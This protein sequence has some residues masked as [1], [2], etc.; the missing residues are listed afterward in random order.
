MFSGDELG[1]LL[2]SALA[3]AG[4]PLTV[5]ATRKALPAGRKPSVKEV[6]DRLG[7]LVDAGRIYRWPGATKKFSAVEPHAFAREH[8]LRALTPGPLTEAEVKK[9]VAKAAQPLVK[10]ALTHLVDTGV[11]RRH[12]KLGQKVPYGLGPPDP[13]AYLPA[14]IASAFKPLLKLGFT[15][16]AL[17][18]AL[19]EYVARP[20]GRGGTDTVAAIFA[21]MSTLNSQASRGALVYIAEL[22]AALRGRFSDKASFDAAILAL[23]ERGEVQL[24]SHAWPGR[25][26][27]AEKDALI[28]NGRGGFFD[29]IGRRLE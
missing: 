3:R 28:A 25:L 23:A 19:R 29:A 21:A 8:V 12:P 26:S 5:T 1:A 13:R 18:Q 4:E 16:P 22:R 14:A 27:D 6:E 15:E 7:A 17:R 24:Q 11:V 20:D 9:Q 10:A 2:E